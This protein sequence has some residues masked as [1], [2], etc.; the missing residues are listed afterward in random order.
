MNS[1]VWQ[2]E[3]PVAIS[4]ITMCAHGSSG[5]QTSASPVPL[6]DVV[7]TQPRSTE[8]VPPGVPTAGKHALHSLR[9][10]A[11]HTAASPALLHTTLPGQLSVDMHVS[12]S[13]ATAGPPHMPHSFF[14]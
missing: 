2:I 1:S 3:L 5:V 7:P 10:G 9:L 11:L 12:P 14:S 8:H 13:P 4:L 6:Q